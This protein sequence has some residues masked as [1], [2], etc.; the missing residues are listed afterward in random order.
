MY[1]ETEAC[2]NTLPLAQSLGP[3]N[4]FIVFEVKGGVLI[5]WSALYHHTGNLL[6]RSRKL[7]DVSIVF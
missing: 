1:Y 2:C 3:G 6:N 4:K 5:F 7:L